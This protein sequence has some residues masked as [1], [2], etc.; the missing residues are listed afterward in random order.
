MASQDKIPENIIIQV[1]PVYSRRFACHNNP[2]GKYD[3]YYETECD[4]H[5]AEWRP[6]ESKSKPETKFESGKLIVFDPTYQC[7]FILCQ[8]NK[9]ELTSDDLKLMRDNQK[10]FY[11][12]FDPN[13]S[14][15]N[16]T[17]QVNRI[18]IFLQYHRTMTETGEQKC[19]QVELAEQHASFYGNMVFVRYLKQ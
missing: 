19:V 11:A 3:F 1:N 17:E 5:K 16:I 15:S 6:C 10:P 8:S 12:L 13:P 4:S 18:P 2:P 9:I 14:T 7:N